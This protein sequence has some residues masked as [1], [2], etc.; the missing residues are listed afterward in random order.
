MGRVGIAELKNAISRHLARV[1]AGETLIVTDH[2]RPIARLVPIASGGEP[3]ERLLELERLGMLRLGS[4]P[5][6]ASFWALPRPE[7]PAG[8]SLALVLTDREEDG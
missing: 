3:E 8:R 4:G 7:D 5:L 1:K 2:G 6:D